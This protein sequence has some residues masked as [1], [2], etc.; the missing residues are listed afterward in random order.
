MKS[1]FFKIDKR[2][3]YPALTDAKPARL[4]S[5]NYVFSINNKY[6]TYLG[7][8]TRDMKILKTENSKMPIKG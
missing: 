3:Q 4:R 1:I 7:L 6:S 8:F 2:K 5:G